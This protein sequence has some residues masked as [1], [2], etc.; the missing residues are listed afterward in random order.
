MTRLFNLLMARPKTALIVIFVL[1]AII[2]SG[3]LRLRTDFSPEQ[4][5]VGN[6]TAVEFCEAHKS[7]FR[8]ED[9][10]V[11]VLLEATDDRSLLREDC[12]RWMKQFAE[13]SRE[14][15]GVRDVTSIITLRRP[16]ISLRSGRNI[17][18]LPLLAEAQYS[19]PELLQER[20]RQLPL[21][22]DMLISKD[23]QL[24]MT[25]VD[26]DPDDR[27]ITTATQRVSRIEQILQQTELPPGTRTFIS[28][29]PAIRVDVIRSILND[30]IRMVP[31]CSALFLIVSLLIFRG[32]LITGLSLFSVLTAVALTLGLMGW[33][34]IAF[35]IMSN[36]IPTLILIIGAANNVH[37]LSRFQV[38]VRAC[39]RKRLSSAVRPEDSD[40]QLESAG[41]PIRLG[42]SGADYATCARTT[43]REMSRTC[44]LTL[45]TTGIGF[46]SLLIA[47][48]DVLKAVAIQAAVGMAC[49]YVSL[50]LVLPP[51]LI[52]CGR[53][54]CPPT[55][56]KGTS[57]LTATQEA[58]L[59][60]ETDKE[61]ATASRLGTIWQVLGHSISVYSVP[62][63]AL[64]LLVAG[65]TLWS[66]RN[67]PI[68]SYVFETYD[69]NHSTMEAVRTMDE[70]M[71][72]LIS[73]EIQLQ[74]DNRD[75]FFDADVAAALLTMRETIPR[76]DTVT[77]YRDY[78][79]FLAVFDN[80]RALT[81]DPIQAA[82]SLRRIRIA[83]KQ[84][85]TPEAT[86][87]FL[88][89]HEPVARVMMRIKDV[90]S[91]GM[92]QL[93]SNVED[94][95]RSELPSDIHFTLT[96]DAYLHAVCM[97]VFVRDLFYSLFAASGIIF[98][99]ISLLF[100]SLRIGLIS[101]VPNMFPL[102]MTLGYMNL[103]GYE[104]TA[105]NVI[106]F[107][108][109]LGIVVDDTIHFLARYRDERRSMTSEH[110]IQEALSSSGRAI[111][112]TSVLVVS[113]LSIL[114]FSE[115]VP[116][117]R[118]AELT[119]ITMCAA[120]PGDVILLPAL[121]KLFGGRSGIYRVGE[122]HVDKGAS[123]PA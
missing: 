25:L 20:I 27:T 75:R 86:S 15:D 71:S 13:Q 35:S 68:N 72:G 42:I 16:R 88:G 19:N 10:I 104:L 61:P 46:G 91:T 52:L 66:C 108:I 11:L 117:R 7:L 12:L 21:L 114:I 119:A 43:M 51:M 63:V 78:V 93:F 111:I 106:V 45:A 57:R 122:H 24:L 83:L 94:T 99:L 23:Q 17:S 113:G 62:I 4:V 8:F 30:Q 14:V 59:E 56:R 28:G 105:G 33:C 64:H 80:N 82:A 70:R 31:L 53:R 48:A 3:V 84:L 38:E 50:M 103:R 44:F 92:K 67:I 109:S 36:I 65:W 87:A 112:L 89:T 110:A 29:V 60:N 102:V 95:L 81:R 118:F 9:S 107:A 18:W 22:N 101:A 54:L 69:R 121:L 47:Q 115:F 74:V 58:S 55:N 120:L 79:E 26:L 2:G 73:L 32:L 40:D 96:G 76:D 34:G 37:I 6:N 100:R 49:C 39:G 116:T 97:D 5:Y 98:L 41:E 85:K 1:T 77:F 123:R 90:G